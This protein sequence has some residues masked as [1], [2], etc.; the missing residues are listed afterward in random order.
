MLS[1]NLAAIGLG[2]EREDMLPEG[3]FGEV[4]EGYAEHRGAG[5]HLRANVLGI[6]QNH[7]RNG[8]HL[9]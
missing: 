3:W 4:G 5:T 1:I 7:G 9:T 2:S 8:R 6:P